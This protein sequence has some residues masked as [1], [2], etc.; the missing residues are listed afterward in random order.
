M[1]WS[2]YSN[3]VLYTNVF[4]PVIVYFIHVY[5]TSSGVVTTPVCYIVL[6]RGSTAL[7]AVNSLMQL[8]RLLAR[9]FTALFESPTHLRE[10]VVFKL[11]NW[12]VSN[13]VGATQNRWNFGSTFFFVLPYCWYHLAKAILVAQHMYRTIILSINTIAPILQAGQFHW[14][15]DFLW[16]CTNCPWNDFSNVAFSELVL[17]RSVLSCW[18]SCKVIFEKYSCIKD[19]VYVSVSQT[20]AFLLGSHIYIC[21][22]MKSDPS[23]QNYFSSALSFWVTRCQLYLD[24]SW[25]PS[26]KSWL[27]FSFVS[28]ETVLCFW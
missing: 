14:I 11:P 10:T 22:F 24:S 9:F 6:P 26:E 27:T 1:Q 21:T 18:L 3:S 20:L 7:Q 5:T 23:R 4:Y 25:S 19:T 17:L 2:P 13:S 15:Y 28:A 8:I 12:T 16:P